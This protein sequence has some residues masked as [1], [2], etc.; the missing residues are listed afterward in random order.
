MSKG[1]L[2]CVWVFIN[3]M[4][5]LGCH[6][7][8]TIHFDIDGQ[9]S[10]TSTIAIDQQTFKVQDYYLRIPFC[11]TTNNGTIIV[12]ADVREHTSSDQALISIGIV[13]SEDGGNSFQD[14]QIIIPHTLESDWDRAMDATILVNRTTGRIFVFA[15]RITSTYIWEQTHTSGEYGF[16]CVY[17]YS[18]DDGKTWSAPHNLFDVL[19]VNYQDVISLFGGVG[20]G[21]TMED[22]TL[23]LPIQCKMAMDDNDKVFNIQSGIIYSKDNGQSWKASKSLLPCY[24]SENMVV[25]YAP[26]QLMMNSRSYIG[27]RRIFTTSDLG[28]TWISHPTDTTLIE[29]KACQG[30]FHKVGEWTFFLNPHHSQE[31]SHLTLQVTDDYVTWTSVLELEERPLFGYSCLCSWKNHLYAVLETKGESIVLYEIENE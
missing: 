7:R 10:Y 5:M 29:P 27:K 11:E 18:D 21:I 17:V 28:E 4:M 20:H 14:A 16:G 22:G 2:K 13:R 31:R 8:E 1:I 9:W 3:A 15:H 26:H 6:S 12:G 23:V 19:D 25:E 24:S 30:S